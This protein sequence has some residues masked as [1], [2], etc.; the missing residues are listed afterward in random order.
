MY[1]NIFLAFA[2]FL[3]FFGFSQKASSLTPEQ[4]AVRLV[5]DELF[6]G[7]HNGDSAR[8]HRTFAK[9]ARL[10]TSYFDHNKRPAMQE[11][12]LINFLNEVGSKHTEIWTEKILSCEIHIDDNF[13]Q[14]W[15]SYE[16]YLGTT[17]SHC[18]VDAFQLLKE[19]SGWKI[20]N[21]TDTRRKERCKPE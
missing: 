21:L 20:I 15:A 2:L 7:M 16:F 12:K 13:A 10:I 11:D 3:S 18:G 14:V 6:A 4:E 9:D 17:F 5:I 19:P 1:R 8:V